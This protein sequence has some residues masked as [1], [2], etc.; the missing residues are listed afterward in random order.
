MSP[1]N[2]SPML[3]VHSVELVAASI[4]DVVKQTVGKQRLPGVSRGQRA[5]SLYEAEGRSLDTLVSHGMI[6]VDI[7]PV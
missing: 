2:L 6:L 5:G 7:R 4:A 1:V 3:S